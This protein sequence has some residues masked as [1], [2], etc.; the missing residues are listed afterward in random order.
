VPGLTENEQVRV[1]MQAFLEAL[2]SYPKSFATNPKLTFEQYRS[3]LIIF[4]ETD[5]SFTPHQTA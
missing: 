3:R 1:E 2:A 4:H 5:R